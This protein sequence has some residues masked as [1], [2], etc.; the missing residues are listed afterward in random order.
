MK[1][2]LAL[3]LL[4]AATALP[5]IP[6]GAQAVEAATARRFTLTAG[7]IMSGFNPDY[8]DPGYNGTNFLFGG[9]TYVDVHFSHWVQIEGEARWLHIT[10]YADSTE[11]Q[12]NYL[13]GPRVPIKQF[14]RFQTYGKVLIGLASMNFPEGGYYANGRFTDL[15]FGGT[16]DYRLNRR[17]SI[18]ALDFEYQD[19]P[20]FVQTNPGVAGSPTTSL[21]PYGISVG[22][23]Y[24]IF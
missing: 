11:S 12:N 16:V 4:C 18:R 1:K 14:G 15:A 6:A 13:I 24:R 17:W 3:F 2:I 20:K 22:I 9:G 23:G 10:T 21:Q 8:A 5:A 19:W 7:G